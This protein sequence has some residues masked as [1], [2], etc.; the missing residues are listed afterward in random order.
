MELSWYTFEA[1]TF[2]CTLLT[3]SDHMKEGRMS[4]CSAKSCNHIVKRYCLKL[5]ITATKGRR[6]CASMRT[7][8][9]TAL[10]SSSFSSIF[11]SLE[12]M[13]RTCAAVSSGN[14]RYLEYRTQSSVWDI[15]TKRSKERA[16]VAQES[17]V[18]VVLFHTCETS[19]R[20]SYLFITLMRAACRR[21]GKGRR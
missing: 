11:S 17:E 12:S 15:K 2:T 7:R 6:K 21:E 5:D 20:D 13:S 8:S 14:S 4:L 9:K 19:A 18:S 16:S 3:Q 1:S 10:N